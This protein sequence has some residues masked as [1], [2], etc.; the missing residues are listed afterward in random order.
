MK[1][2][3]TVRFY[4]FTLFYCFAMFFFHLFFV[5]FSPFVQAKRDRGRIISERDDLIKTLNARSHELSTHYEMQHMQSS[6][7]KDVEMAIQQSEENIRFAQLELK[8]LQ[9]K[10]A[11]LQKQQETKQ[12]LE[13]DLVVNQVC[14]PEC[15]CVRAC[16]CVC[17][18]VR[19]RKS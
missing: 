2:C 14:V 12:T 11:A 1:K 7:L 4:I 6:M 8:Q 19:K 16:V 18:A 15:I 5:F 13:Q 3:K 17:V 10:I 9:G